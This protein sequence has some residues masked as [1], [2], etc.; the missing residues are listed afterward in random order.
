[1]VRGCL[2][3]RRDGGGR[4]RDRRRRGRRRDEVVVVVVFL[5]RR[6]EPEGGGPA[7]PLDAGVHADHVRAHPRVRRFLGTCVQVIVPAGGVVRL[8]WFCRCPVDHDA[9][10]PAAVVFAD[11]RVLL[12]GG[13]DAAAARPPAYGGAEQ[14]AL[15]LDARQLLRLGHRAALRPKKG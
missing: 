4:R 13:R 14:A 9:P 6:G 1:V 10:V 7:T 12:P 8:Q 15:R 3:R 11:G 2:E 5:G